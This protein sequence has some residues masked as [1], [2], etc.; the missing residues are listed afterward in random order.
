MTHLA[1]AAVRKCHFVPL[2]FRR[3]ATL[4]LLIAW[5]CANGGI[6]DGVQVLA[7]GRMF[8]ANATTMSWSSAL[9]A[10]FDPAKRCEICEVVTSARAEVGSSAARPDADD[11]SKIV[12]TVVPVER[13]AFAPRSASYPKQEVIPG[14][15][16]RDP[17]PLPPPRA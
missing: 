4:S 9:A 7:W 10:T 17:T 8:A 6:W 11:R 2:V 14:P 12:L 5:L 3:V 1:L 16:R 15:Q 13:T